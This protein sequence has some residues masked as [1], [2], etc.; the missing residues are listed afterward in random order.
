MFTR[1]L[2]SSKIGFHESRAMIILSLNVEHTVR[3]QQVLL[4]KNYQLKTYM[5]KKL[6]GAQSWKTK[7]LQE[8]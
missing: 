5:Y 4:T 1:T 6:V 3:T 2:S 8:N 7:E